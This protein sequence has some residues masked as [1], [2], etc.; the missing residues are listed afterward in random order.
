M[1]EMSHVQVLRVKPGDVI[2]M[3][4]PEGQPRPAMVEL[5]RF[6]EECRK[7]FPG[8]RVLVLAGGVK[9]WVA[10]PDENADGQDGDG[11]P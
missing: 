11:R 9:L 10:R 6:S 3:E 5:A 7:V 8:N 4:W 2:V 1:D